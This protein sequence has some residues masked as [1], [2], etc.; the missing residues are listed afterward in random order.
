PTLDRVVVSTDDPHVAEV[1]RGHG[2]DVPFLRPS[3]LA[4][5]IPSLKPVIVHAV[6]E[7]EKAGDRPDIVV[8]L[9]ATTPFRESFAIEEAVEKLVAGGDGTGVSVDQG[10]PR[11]LTGGGPGGAR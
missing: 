5:D 11:K 4:A 8:I 1:A 6:R 10:R 3:D 2:A 7:L 9:Q